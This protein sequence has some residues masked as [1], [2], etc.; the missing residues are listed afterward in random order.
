MRLNCCRRAR[1][2][3]EFLFK[4]KTHFLHFFLSVFFDSKSPRL[5]RGCSSAPAMPLRNRRLRSRSK[6][7]HRSKKHKTA[8]TCSRGGKGWHGC[9]H[10]EICIVFSNAIVR[11]ST[12]QLTVVLHR[13]TLEWNDVISGHLHCNGVLTR[14]LDHSRF[15]CLRMPVCVSLFR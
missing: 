9:P 3:L 7:R 1:R 12:V 13:C 15:I 6:L 14:A 10:L 8:S 11:Q 4:Q 2:V 5:E